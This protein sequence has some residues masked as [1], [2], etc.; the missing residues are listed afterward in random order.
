MVAVEALRTWAEVA[1]VELRWA[2][3]EGM[4]EGA[5]GMAGR[6]SQVESDPL[7]APM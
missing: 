7:E 5:G 1:D 6:S 2:A 4:E 3:E